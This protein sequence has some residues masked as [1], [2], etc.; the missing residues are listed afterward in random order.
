MK[1]RD[2]KI[3]EEIHE[4]KHQNFMNFIEEKKRLILK[5]KEKK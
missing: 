5:A 1:E 4:K 2:R 3:K